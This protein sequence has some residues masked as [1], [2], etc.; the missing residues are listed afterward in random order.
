MKTIAAIILATIFLS[1][2]LLH[3]YWVFGG[4][5]GLN[6]AMP[7]TMK[8]QVMIVSRRSWFKIA[9]L[10]VALGLFLMAYIFLIQAGVAKSPVVYRYVEY[11]T[12]AVCGIFLLRAIGDFKYCGFF[13]SI[14][15]G[16]FA[17]SD[18]KYFSPLCLFIS[19][20]TLVV[21]YL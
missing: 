11:A 1:I 6:S 17:R 20:L 18:T 5:W 19:I 12:Y 9:T 2:A 8:E 3:V 4:K 21:I 15:E 14:K 13:K 16:D 10:I 7:N